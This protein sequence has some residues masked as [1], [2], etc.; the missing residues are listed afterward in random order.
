[1]PQVIDII[2]KMFVLKLLK[3]FKK[4]QIESDSKKSASQIVK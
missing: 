4:R 2:I 1:M 3:P